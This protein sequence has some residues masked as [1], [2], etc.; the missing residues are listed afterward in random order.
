MLIPTN[1]P[2]LMMLLLS[3]LLKLHTADRQGCMACQTIHLCL[4]MRVDDGKRV[5]DRGK[6][7]FEEVMFPE[8]EALISAERRFCGKYRDK[9]MKLTPR[10]SLIFSDFIV[11]RSGGSRTQAQ[12]TGDP[13]SRCPHPCCLSRTCSG[14]NLALTF[15]FFF[16]PL[17]TTPLGDVNSPT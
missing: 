7:T 14:Q 4:S 11:E 16:H 15:H 10:Y 6:R 12:R 5:E 9:I 17:T 8:E 2:F 13:A 1:G 3:E